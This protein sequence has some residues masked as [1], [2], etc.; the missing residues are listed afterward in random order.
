MSLLLYAI[1]FAGSRQGAQA[2]PPLP[3]GVGGAPI[4]MVEASGLAA[5][6]SRVKSS[7]LAPSVARALAY[8][9]V[10]EALHADRT[11]LPLRYGCV[12]GQESDVVERLRA[13]RGAYETRLWELDG[14][15]EMGVR[16]L[17]ADLGQ[18]GCGDGGPNGIAGRRD[19]WGSCSGTAYLNRRKA[20]HAEQARRTHDA[21]MSA[22]RLRTALAGQCLRC[23]TDHGPAPGAHS[24]FRGALLSVHFLVTR[25]AIASFRT[26]FLRIDVA[27]RARL[28]LSGPW[29]PYNFAQP[30]VRS[31]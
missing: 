19:E 9:E 5:A 8:A 29:P 23:R 15:V 24:M 3:P 7:D 31:A 21:A 20:L 30:D 13:Q 17:V 25:A 6:V 12:L 11:V 14:C 27:E 26:A 22:R 2:L 18:A 4:R 28:L 1:V 10:V 16:I